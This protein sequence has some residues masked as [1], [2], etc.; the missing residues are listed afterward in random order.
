VPL[1]DVSGG[2]RIDAGVREGHLETLRGGIDL[3]SMTMAGRA[4]RNFRAE[5]LKPAGK[6]ELHIDKMRG[7]IAGGGM[8]GRMT[9]VYP[10]D[11]PS[12]Y[13]LEL[14]VRDADVRALAWEKAD[15][16][17]NGQLT[18]SL[19]VEGS[20]GDVAQRRGRGDVMVSGRDMYRIPLVLGLLQVTNLALPISSPF[21]EAT[22][23]YNL[24]GN[25]VTFEQIKLTARNMLME[26]SGSL[27]FGTKKV[28]LAF[29]T[30][31]PSGLM[32]L[33]F[34]KELWSGARNEMLKIRVKGTIQE[35]EVSAQSM[36]TFWTTVDEVLNGD[37]KAA[38]DKKRRDK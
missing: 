4:T 36:G 2:V 14:V 33:P 18:A 27:D 26:G 1:T 3:D 8:S 15:D 21:N 24:D 5:L 7:D 37:K 10:D 32:Q 19:S 35:P 12:R 31:N 34:L 17:M 25:R 11:G 16:K 23:V 20:W 29:T 22:A 6:S 9:L 30:D 13:A 38:D 28:D